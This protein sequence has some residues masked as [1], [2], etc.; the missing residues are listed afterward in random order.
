MSRAD[1]F[2]RYLLRLFPAEFRGDFGDQMAATFSDQRRHEL[3]RGG[4]MGALRFWWDTVRGIM[5]TAPREHLDVVCR[6]V[7]FALRTL[8]RQKGFTAVAVLALAVGIGAN[9]AVFTIVNGVLL[10]ALPYQDPQRLVLLFEQLPSVPIKFGFSPPD[11]EIVRDLA[12][13]YSG[14]AAY[15]NV[16]LELS[17]VSTPQR[18][19]GARVLPGLFAVLGVGPA[20]GRALTED[21]DRQGAR[22][23]MVSHNLW[24]QTFGRDPSLVG[25]TISLDGRPYT[26]VGI[27]PDSLVFPPRKPGLNGRPADVFVPMS[28]SPSERQAFGMMYNNTVVARLAPGVSIEQARAELST[29]VP[30]LTDRYPA[31][32]QA[33]TA[34]LSIPIT[35]MLDETVG[36][37]RR[38]LLVLMAAVSL[39]L[40]IACADVAGLILTRSASRQRELAIR[41]ALGATR[42]RIV[43]QLV[44]EAVVLA[45]AGSAAGL[46]LAYWLMR[47]LLSLAGEKLP[48]TESIGFDY[49]IVLF[50]VALALITPLA[51]GIVPAIRAA[52]ATIGDGLKETTRTP[53]SGRRPLSLLGL[54]VVGQ[55][56]VALVLSVGAGLLVRSFVRLVQTD[57]GFRPAQTVRATMTLPIGRYNTPDQVKAFYQRSIDAART[58]P[59]VLS[60][61]AGSDLP[62]GV[63]DRRAFSADPSAQQIPSQSR[64][65][66]PTWTAGSY[67]DA[68]GIALVRGRFFTDTDGPRSERVVIV[69]DRLARLLWP[70]ADPVGRR[71]RWGLDIAENQNPWMTIVGVVGNVKQTGLDTPAIEQVYVPLVQDDAGGPLLRTVNVVVRSTRDGASLITDIRGVLRALDTDLPAMLQTLQDMIGASVQPQR[72]SLMVMVLFAG[73]ALTLA[74]FGVYGV[75]ANSVAQQAKEIG[76]RVALGASRGN[77]IWLVLRRA[78][79]L[80]SI[81][82]AIG[83]AGALAATRAMTGLLFEVRPTDA[84]S[85]LGAAVCLALIALPASLVPAWRATRV[86]PLVALR[87]E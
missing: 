27:M 16:G 87:T 32:L 18:L 23:A 82:L 68:L 67:F 2:F 58:I 55:F 33:F 10:Q 86:D 20:I 46:L 34:R 49:R 22:V 6:D 40:L 29:L 71:I 35:P 80:T 84:A 36:G 79:A 42:M 83:G 21:D 3:A 13:S 54:L 76:I 9:T 8:R 12:R 66:A 24:T 31:F 60:I 26:V 65:I 45:A 74:A 37:S 61:G 53:A 39:V 41:S 43:R 73:L 75:L 63:R 70:D 1:R 38:L 5:A 51:F 30:A 62:L 14:F 19:D 48:L 81:G 47:A 15:R 69:N 52:R 17:G 72:F 56:A 57:P 59:G 4:F 77:V 64:L 78:L 85:F 7:G 11:F 50:A 28:F 44:T 25:R